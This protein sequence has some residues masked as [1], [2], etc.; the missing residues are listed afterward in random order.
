MADVRNFQLSSK[1]F[2][3]QS[4]GLAPD[5][6]EFLAAVQSDLNGLQEMVKNL[7]GA[8]QLYFSSRYDQF[9][10][11]DADIT[12]VGADKIVGLVSADQIDSIAADQITGLI[13]ASQ[14]NTVAAGQITGSI[15]AGQINSITAGQITGTIQSSQIDSIAA[16]KITGAIQATQIASINA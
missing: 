2:K 3:L 5:S 12:D 15:L 6:S 14:I 10:A 7:Q 8:L 16:N 1:P 11:G 13:Q 9:K 4:V